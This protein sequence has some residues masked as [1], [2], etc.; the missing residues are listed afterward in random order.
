MRK[1]G[2]CSCVSHRN[3]VLTVCQSVMKL[4][5]EKMLL[6]AT[7]P[8][9]FPSINKNSMATVRTGEVGAMWEPVHMSIVVYIFC[10]CG[11]YL[12]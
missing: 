10:N 3:D 11:I 2:L 1:D 6:D 9:Y 7:S 8:F 5:G 4:G 12:L